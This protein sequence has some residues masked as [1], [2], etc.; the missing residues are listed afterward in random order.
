ML[1]GV[2]G[3]LAVGVCWFIFN[4]MI[5]KK[6]L[7]AFEYMPFIILANFIYTFY[8]FTIQYIYKMKK[9]IIM[10]IIT[11]SGSIIQMLLSYWLIQE[12]GVI[13]AVYSLL[14][15]NLLIT[16]CIFIYSNV[17][18]DMPWLCF[19]SREMH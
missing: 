9:T 3:V 16:L 12:Y 7:L 11:F 6:Y 5:D 1:F 18:Y 10:G 15:G 19:Y 14:I 2:V 8:Q 13:G 4:F 17:V